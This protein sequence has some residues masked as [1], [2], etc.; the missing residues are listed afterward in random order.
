M[1][2]DG[3]TH[4]MT[5]PERRRSTQNDLVGHSSR[6]FWSAGGGRWEPPEKRSE[7]E[8]ANALA[9]T[10]VRFARHATVSTK[11]RRAF[12]SFVPCARVFMKPR[13][14]LTDQTPRCTHSSEYSVL[15][16]C[17]WHKCV[18]TSRNFQALLLQVLDKLRTHVEKYVCIQ[19]TDLSV[20]YLS[21]VV[22]RTIW[23]NDEPFDLYIYALERDFRNFVQ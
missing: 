3:K 18:L 23:S 6:N 10:S 17:V 16:K 22:H 8:A 1:F 21:R 15:G 14:N 2:L 9:Q 19:L 7:F 4:S 13:N 20:I 12:L 5:A 11:L